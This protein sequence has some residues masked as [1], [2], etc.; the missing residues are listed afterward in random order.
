MRSGSP[1]F[2]YIKPMMMSS[3]EHDNENDLLKA[4]EKIAFTRRLFLRSIGL[5]GLSLGIQ[6]AGFSQE[7]DP[8]TG[9]SARFDMKHYYGHDAVLDRNG[10]IAPWYQ[11]LNGQCDFRIRIAA[12]TLK[13]YPWTTTENAVAAYPDYLFT[14]NW[15]I[16]QDG[17]ITRK[18][19]GDWSNGDLGQ[20]STSVL[21]GM[22]DYYRYSGDPAAI[23]H[24]TYMGNYVLDYC[25][26]PEDHSWPA[27]PISVPVKGKPYGKADPSGMIQLDICASM[28]EGLLKAYQVT[29]NQRW[30]E[31]A[32]HWGD[33]FAEKRNTTISQ[34]PWPRYA[35]PESAPWKDDP[36]GNLQT[37]GVTMVVA[38]LDEL[39]RLGYTGKDHAIITARDAGIHYLREDL[40]PKWTVD[41]TWGH[42]FWDWLNQTQNCSTT[43]DVANYIIRHKELFPNWRDDARNILTVFLNHSGADPKSGG[44]V[45]NGAWAYPESSSC[46]GRSLWYAPLMVGAIMAEYGVVADDP[47][48]RELA[49]RQMILQTYDVHETGVTE[50]NIDGGVIVN[51]S[52]LNIAHPWP[53]LWV[54]QAIGWLPE[55]LGASRENHLVRTTSVVD[56]IIYGKGSIT[57]TTFDA[58]IGT[59]DVLRL[60]FVPSAISADGHPLMQHEDLKSNGY[61]IKKLPNGDAIVN[62]RHD[63]LK[64]INVSGPDPQAE[65]MTTALQFDGAWKQEKDPSS[66]SGF[67]NTAEDGQASVTAVFQGNQVRVIGRAEPHGGQA[68]VF[69][70]GVLQAVF[71]D[72]WNQEPRSQQTLYYKNGL[73]QGQHTLKIVARGKANPYSGGTRINIDLLQFSAA[74]DRYGF[75]TG[76]GPTGSQR[77]IFGYT[78]RQDYKDSL[79]HLWRPAT[80]VITRLSTRDDTVAKCWMPENSN[81]ISGVADAEL[82][83]YGYRAND[84]WVNLTVGPGKYGVRLRFAANLEASLYQNGFDV[85]INEKTLVRNLDVRGT[86]KGNAV[87]DL[88][89]KD[90]APYNGIIQVRFMSVK[91]GKAGS[92][93]SASAFVQA[94]EIGPDLAGPGAAPVSFHA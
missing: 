23:A 66:R 64:K 86:A 41:N 46:C 85:V 34:P 45:Y 82:Y 53:L 52:W 28:G 54:Q 65:L 24:L 1:Q 32:K 84:F 19:L 22:T 67:V 14:S 90:I 83:R 11:Q 25:L 80:E 21:K 48:M 93:E 29:K 38:F 9:A 13:R 4:V 70:D 33:L 15:S 43:A 51:D 62:I 57:Y 42:F 63:A 88:F 68:D 10:V 77:M 58:P 27:F 81:V 30:F 79:G 37:G 56:S 35:N 17:T 18:H 5:G 31:A 59:T 40:L 55:E 49:Y 7:N 39:I 74:G 8:L 87:A 71:I 72:F 6:H 26:T 20:R 12:E 94:L 69:V 44:N 16:A 3:H 47:L 92:T 75:P 36:L 61:T 89:F 50:D 2:L 78:K 73:S 76:T 91:P 60:S